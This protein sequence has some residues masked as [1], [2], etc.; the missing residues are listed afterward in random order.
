V[1]LA[2]TIPA[3]AIAGVGAAA[4]AP[5]VEGAAA[6]AAGVLAGAGATALLAAQRLRA[7]ERVRGRRLLHEARLVRPLDRSSLYL[8][9]AALAEH[10]EGPAPQGPWPSHR[11]PARPQRSAIELE[12][13]NGAAVHSV[14]VRPRPPGRVSAAATPDPRGPS[15]G[16]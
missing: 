9:P 14:G 1:L 6:A 11:P 4:A 10:P 13:S 8:E 12:P 3:A 2:R 16:G 5:H 15:A 7:V